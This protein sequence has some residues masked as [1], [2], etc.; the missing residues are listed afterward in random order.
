MRAAA[1]AVGA[2]TDHAASL[3]SGETN[4]GT[5]DGHETPSGQ[6]TENQ[7]MTRSYLRAVKD[8][9]VWMR[10]KNRQSP[11]A[12]RATVLADKPVAAT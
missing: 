1:V 5:S 8:A 6:F 12:W 2:Q 7:S 10:S 11:A 9:P 4:G 3:V